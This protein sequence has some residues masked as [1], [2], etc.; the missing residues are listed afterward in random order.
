MERGVARA[1]SMDSANG[2][3]LEGLR[4]LDLGLL[5]QGP[6]A[7]QLLADL[8][9]DVIKVELPRLGDQARW[10]PISLEDRRAPYFI[11]CNR[12]CEWRIISW[13]EGTEGSQ[14]STDRR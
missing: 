11:G 6:Q 3:A 2:G 13:M 14:G 9:A 5:V 8:G 7:A 1:M 12:G 4:V 10:I